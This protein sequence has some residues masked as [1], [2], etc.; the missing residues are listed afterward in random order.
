MALAA[1][2]GGFTDRHR[3]SAERARGRAVG[4]EEGG[5]AGDTHKR[6]RVVSAPPPLPPPTTPT[7]I[8]RF[9]HTHICTNLKRSRA[10]HI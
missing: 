2:Q 1:A 4:E 3:G 7:L 10:W 8:L 9:R 6:V 5:G